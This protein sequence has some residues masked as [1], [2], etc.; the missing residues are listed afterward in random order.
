[1]SVNP[2]SPR[3]HYLVRPSTALLTSGFDP[4]LS[5]GS[6]RPAVFR[7]ST[8]V[9]SSPE[10]AERAFDIA[11]GRSTAEHDENV[12]LIYARLSHPNAEILEDHLVA[13]EPGATSAAVFN[14]GLAAISTVFLTRCL[15][16]DSIIYVT[17]LYGGTQHLI[18]SLLEPLGILGVPAPAGDNEALLSAIANA[19]RPALIFI[20]SPANPTLRM[21]DIAA[22]VA[23]AK[24]HT[25][26]PLVAVD[27]TMMGPTFQ[28]PLSL[29]A[30]L[31]IYS[32]TKYLAGFS[33]M[34]GGVVLSG[35]PPLIEQLRGTRAILG[36]ILQPDEC[37]LLDGRLPTV[38]LRMNR[39]SKNAQRIAE[40]LASHPRIKRM[41]YPLFIDE[42]EQRR[43][44]DAQCSF[45]GAIISLDLHGGKCAA[46]DFLR[47]LKIV[48]NAVSLGG[49]ESLACHPATT[50]HSEYSAAELHA[51]GIGP[52]LVRISVG[53]ED[54]RDLLRDLREALTGDSHHASEV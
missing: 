34:L 27:N 9:F 43:I 42:P 45:P 17:P 4:R 54:W 6:A 53:I 33:D 10:A 26:R 46:F 52:G 3:P 39:Q 29:G 35:E 51:S 32:A 22:A 13:L 37:W 49:V 44:R 50:T 2:P 20:E 1:M 21:T 24:R 30:D 25:A 5:V 12:E 36:N 23:A 31:S 47:R 7:S 28:H 38:S 41:Y 15:A 11:L 16:G 8:Y 18:R 14:S 48:R 40:Q 19:A